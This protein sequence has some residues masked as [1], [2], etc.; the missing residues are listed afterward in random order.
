MGITAERVI[1]LVAATV[2]SLFWIIA[3]TVNH[4]KYEEF[5]RAVDPDEYMYPDIFSVGFTMM[6]IM[7]FDRSSR[8]ARKR[9]REI[10]EVKGRLYAEFHYLVLNAAKWSYGITIFALFCIFGALS[11]KPVTL[12]LGVVFA[13]LM[14]W[15]TDERFNDRLE[16]KRE[17]LLSDFPQMLSK[18]ALLVNSGMTVRNA[19]GKISEDGSG[20][21]LFAEMKQTV[22]EMNNGV[23]ELTA[24]ENFAERCGLKQMR[25]FSATIA[26]AKKK[27]NAEISFFIREL[28]DDMWLEKKNLAKRKGAAAASKLVIPTALIFIGILIMIIVPAFSGM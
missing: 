19:W 17:S 2:S 3:A 24:Y 26:Q 22:Q 27:G 10:A 6:D 7:H 14:M 20:R 25:R 4:S 21:P 15:Y 9:V 18:M 1:L 16:E 5:T 28:A 12:V 11:G 13:G 8:K 23:L